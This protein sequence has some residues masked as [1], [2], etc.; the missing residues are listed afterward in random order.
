MN[1]IEFRKTSLYLIIKDILHTYPKQIV[2]Y[3]FLHIIGYL[4]GLFGVAILARSVHTITTTQMPQFRFDTSNID[5]HEL[6]RFVFH[7]PFFYDYAPLLVGIIVIIGGGVIYKSK[8]LLVN[9]AVGYEKKCGLKTLK[10][11]H[12]S[13]EDSKFI[14]KILTKDC[15]FCGRALF[16]LVL[17]LPIIMSTLI[18]LTVIM[19]LS[20]PLGIIVILCCAVTM[21]VYPFL[22][23][24]NFE[25]S[26]KLEDFGRI[27]ALAKQR[28]VTSRS[29]TDFNIDYH[30]D[31]YFRHSSEAN[32]HYNAYMSRL[33]APHKTILLGVYTSAVILFMMVW[34]V[35]HG[36]INLSTTFILVFL[37]QFTLNGVKSILKGGMNVF[38]F[39]PYFSRYFDFI[40]DNK[41]L[42]N[43]LQDNKIQ[44]YRGENV[45]LI[46]PKI[47]YRQLLGLF[48][49]PFL[50]KPI[51]D[52]GSSYNFGFVNSGFDHNGISLLSSLGVDHTYSVRDFVEE[53]KTYKLNEVLSAEN[54]DLVVSECKKIIE[55]S[56]PVIES[57]WPTISPLTKLVFSMLGH[58]R[59]NMNVMLIRFH[60][61][62][63]IGYEII[64]RLEMN[65]IVVLH[66]NI[67]TESVMKVIHSDLE[68]F[69]LVEA[70]GSDNLIQ[71]SSSA[72]IDSSLEGEDD[73]GDDV[74]S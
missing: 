29:N 2:Y 71:K 24:A 55:S 64:S 61:I 32:D 46:S 62:K 27:D 66:H 25:N 34:L 35:H 37:L 33:V 21:F 17:T 3:C 10:N 12:T 7:H 45:A 69:S 42:Q 74:Y 19:F 20:P 5:A 18:S 44:L 53:I 60:E 26:R 31:A 16:D 15:R 68:K 40:K 63:L 14:L 56:S 49:E 67:L 23:K 65:T 11:L 4:C 48:R 28:L 50:I 72:L 73:V 54:Y 47:N 52:E 43:V 6:V 58:F 38:M 41:A 57:I 36:Y 1:L 9:M 59:Q 13:A 70:K 8:K 51:N 30:I 22:A 39:Q